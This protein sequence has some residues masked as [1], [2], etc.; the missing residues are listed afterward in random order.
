MKLIYVILL[1]SLILFGCKEEEAK[2]G[3]DSEPYKTVSNVEA[4]YMAGK[5]V[6]FGEDGFGICNIEMVPEEIFFLSEEAGW[7]GI[8]VIISGNLHKP[9]PPDYHRLHYPYITLI[10]IKL[11]EK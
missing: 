8:D 9:K 10:D 7:D 5:V 11:W 6:D 4:I 3:C 2:W 1:A